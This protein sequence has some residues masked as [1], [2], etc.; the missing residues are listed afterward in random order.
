MTVIKSNE[1]IELRIRHTWFMLIYPTHFY[2]PII[3]KV[4]LMEH[5][6]Y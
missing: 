4:A 2:N 6:H 3:P 5:N 1:E